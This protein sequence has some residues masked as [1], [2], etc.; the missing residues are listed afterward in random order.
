[1]SGESQAGSSTGQENILAVLL[2]CPGPVVPDT[3]DISIL[4][5]NFTTNGW[6]RARGFRYIDCLDRE[7]MLI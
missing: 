6:K 3:D 1:M 5:F 2:H 4:A 7:N